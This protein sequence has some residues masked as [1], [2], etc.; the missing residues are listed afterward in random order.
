MSKKALSPT[1]LNDRLLSGDLSRRQFHKLLAGAGLALVAAPL[2]PSL[3]A[4]ADQATY[5]TWGGYD[6]PEMF[7]PYVAKHG[8]A[9][10]FAAFGGTEEALTKLMAASSLTSATPATRAWPAGSPRGCSSPWI[11]IACPTGAT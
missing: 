6:I 1:E 10:N 5:F 9:P 3:A 7:A 8:E 11:S 2:T 4:P